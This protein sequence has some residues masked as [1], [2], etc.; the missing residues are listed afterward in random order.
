MKKQRPAL[1][2]LAVDEPV[3]VRPLSAH[4]LRGESKTS[5]DEDETDEL[6]GS[7]DIGETT[8]CKGSI[9][10]NR[11][12]VSFVSRLAKEVEE[13]EELVRPPRQKV[14]ICASFDPMQWS[15]TLSTVAAHFVGRA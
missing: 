2:L 14:Q 11:R 6:E 12:G 4:E 7:C 3:K 8:L 13:D 10:I 5:D 1:T 15:L 9:H